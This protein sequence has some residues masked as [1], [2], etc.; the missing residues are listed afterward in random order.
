M[1]GKSEQIQVL[2]DDVENMLAAYYADAVFDRIK[3]TEDQPSETRI[4]VSGELAKAGRQV[5]LFRGRG[6]NALKAINALRRPKDGADADEQE[7]AMND[8]ATRWT[9]ERIAELHAKVRERMEKFVGSLE[10]KRMAERDAGRADRTMPA[11]PAV[12]GGPPAPAP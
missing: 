8:D 7:T 12:Q 6:T 11:N 3:E 9:P 5:K 2:L 4:K 10:F 1:A